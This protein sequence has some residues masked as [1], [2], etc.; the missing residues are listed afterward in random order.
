M[1]TFPTIQVL[2]GLEKRYKW[3]ACSGPGQHKR[4][5][6]SRRGELRYRKWTCTHC[7]HMAEVCPACKKP[8]LLDEKFHESLKNLYASIDTLGRL[9]RRR[10]EG[11]VL[12][13][14]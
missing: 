1:C 3:T 5:A 6:K 10:E 13:I 11:H 12:S 9:P 4:D 2:E 8:C 14:L 7:Q